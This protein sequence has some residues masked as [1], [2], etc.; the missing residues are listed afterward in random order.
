MAINVAEIT[1]ILKQEIAGFE[2]YAHAKGNAF[3]RQTEGDLAVV[4][5]G[6]ALCLSEAKRGH[7]RVVTFGP[8]GDGDVTDAEV[9][10][11]ARNARY[12]RALFG[13]HQRRP[14]H[15][16]A[17]V[18]GLQEHRTAGGDDFEHHIA[19]HDQIKEAWM[20]PLTEDNLIARESYLSGEPRQLL[21]MLRLESPQ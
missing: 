21:Q 2:A 8:G 17:C 7:G 10:D 19:F 11:P 9:K 14:T 16:V 18:Q 13:I 3:V 4:P 5:A 1:S 12:P 15:G 20:G 6:D